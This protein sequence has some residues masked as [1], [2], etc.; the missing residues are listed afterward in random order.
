MNTISPFL[1]EKIIDYLASKNVNIYLQWK[2]CKFSEDIQPTLFIISN[3]NSIYIK[4][5]HYHDSD[6][7]HWG[8]YLLPYIEKLNNCIQNLE[9]NKTA[10][11][12]KPPDF[13]G[14]SDKKIIVLTFTKS[15]V[16]R[17]K[18]YSSLEVLMYIKINNSE[19]NKLVKC[20]KEIKK[21]YQL[22]QPL[23]CEYCDQQWIKHENLLEKMEEK[24]QRKP[25]S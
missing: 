7:P 4:F 15:V 11:L 18:K 9:L 13:N 23:Y 16:L 22:M 10:E 20:L 25:L 17:I 8:V 12:F 24:C 19:K 3:N 21:F 5:D 14:L 6:N 1:Q 2:K